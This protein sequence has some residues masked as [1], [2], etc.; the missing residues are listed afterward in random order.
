[1]HQAAELKEAA[2]KVVI[3]NVNSLIG[4]E[5]WKECAKNRTHLFV[6]LF[7]EATQT[8]TKIEKEK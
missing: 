1:M 6:D 8:K 2:M 3:K 5:E 4:S 7:A